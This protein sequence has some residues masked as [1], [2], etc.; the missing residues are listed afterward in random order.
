MKISD[1]ETT[2]PVFR[3]EDFLTGALEGLGSSNASRAVFSSSG[4]P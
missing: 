3:P 2:A 1:F 4:S